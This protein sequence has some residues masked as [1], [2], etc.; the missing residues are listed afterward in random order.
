ME[1]CGKGLPVFVKSA[2]IGIDQRRPGEV[3]RQR[4]G[5]DELQKPPVEGAYRKRRLRCQDPLVE[6]A[7][8]MTQFGIRGHAA[9]GEK[10]VVDLVGVCGYYML[11]SMTL[12]V[13]EVPLPPGEPDPLP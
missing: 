1:L 7:R 9:F 2:R 5:I 12:N 11:V 8:P 3:G 13:F 4:C 10:G 6:A